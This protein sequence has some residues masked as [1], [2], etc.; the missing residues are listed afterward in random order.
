MSSDPGHCADRTPA[1]NLPRPAAVTWPWP[2]GARGVLAGVVILAAM[3][4]A[5]AS[6]F[7]KPKSGEAFVVAPELSVDPNTAPAR[8]LTA[9]PHIGPALVREWVAARNARPF[10]SLED[11]R[12][13]VRGL[14]PA[15]LA[16][17]AP[18]LRFEPSTQSDAEHIASSSSNR[19][20]GKARVI[21]RKPARPRST[22]QTLQSSRP[23]LV[24][25]L[26]ELHA[27][28]PLSIAQHD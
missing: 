22:R 27:R 1:E 21:R 23:R 11:A 7:D 2:V 9:L 4:L 24:E 14:G 16:Q 26:S 12:H 15:T 13:R 20:V 25:E 6:R 28:R 17:I 8:V 3:G 10:S 18:Y 5:M 19:P